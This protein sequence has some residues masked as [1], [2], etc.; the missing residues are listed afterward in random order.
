MSKGPFRL[1]AGNL[2]RWRDGLLEAGVVSRKTRPCHD[3]YARIASWP[4]NRQPV[5]QALAVHRHGRASF[6]PRYR[7]P[8]GVT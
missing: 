3:P 6:R 7:L 2:S 5:S 8:Q 1:A 4:P